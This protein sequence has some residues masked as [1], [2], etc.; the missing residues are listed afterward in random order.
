MDSLSAW[1]SRVDSVCSDETTIQGGI[2]VKARAL[3]LTFTYNADL[4]CTRDK[5]SAWCFVDSQTWQG[6]DYIRYD[7]IMCS[8][9]GDDNS[10]VAPQCEDPDFDMDEIDSD[11]AA[12]RNLYGK[13]LVRGHGCVW[14]GIPQ[15]ANPSEQRSTAANASCSCTASVC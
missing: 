15:L 7:P 6:S 14:F 1:E 13:D 4:V 11:M 10:T 2:V 5:E 3:P 12:I 9:N 8:S